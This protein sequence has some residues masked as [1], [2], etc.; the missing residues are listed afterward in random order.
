MQYL[1]ILSSIRA[2]QVCY[3]AVII[4]QQA[5]N[6]SGLAMLAHNQSFNH[7][8]GDTFKI[9]PPSLSLGHDTFCLFAWLCFGEGLSRFKSKQ[10]LAKNR[11]I[12]NRTSNI[13]NMLIPVSNPK[14]PPKHISLNYFVFYLILNYLIIC[15]L[16]FE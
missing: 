6:L 11:T 16:D 2:K 4:V 1:I 14:F 9:D 12:Q 3:S 10:R 13:L 7:V 5:I 15:I 8:I